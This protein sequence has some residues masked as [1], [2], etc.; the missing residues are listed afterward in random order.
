[1][2]H[3][4]FTRRRDVTRHRNRFPDKCYKRDQRHLSPIRMVPTNQI[5]EIR[6]EEAE[7]QEEEDDSDEPEMV[8]KA[9][10]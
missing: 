4:E 2:C 10:Q 7:T 3:Q 1:M 9:E 8:E 5:E 6:R